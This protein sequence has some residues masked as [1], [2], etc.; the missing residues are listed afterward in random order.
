MRVFVVGNGLVVVGG[1]F[2]CSRMIVMVV[3][4]IEVLFVSSSVGCYFVMCSSSV[5]GIVVISCLSWL[6]ILIY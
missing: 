1:F 4:N 3:V 5:N 2:C 6:M